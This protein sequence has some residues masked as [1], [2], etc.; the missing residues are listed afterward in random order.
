VLG[1]GVPLQ[2]RF[3]DVDADGHRRELRFLPP[4]TWRARTALPSETRGA[5]LLVG[6]VHDQNAAA[7]GP[8]D[9]A[10][11]RG[12]S[13][14]AVGAFARHLFQILDGRTGVVAEASLRRFVARREG[15]PDSSRALGWDTML[16]T[17]S[18]G[19]R[20]SAAAFGHTCFTGTARSDTP[21]SRGVDNAAIRRATTA[22]FSAC[23]RAARRRDG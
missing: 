17:S 4:D 18:F 2:Q 12:R 5:Q 6:E 19:T 21:S 15:V 10:T 11:K 8:I 23:A 14:V 7:L 20:M 13:A 22:R 1:R 16:P 3:D 9:P